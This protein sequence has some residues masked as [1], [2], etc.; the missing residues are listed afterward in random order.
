MT[1]DEPP[2]EHWTTDHSPVN[3]AVKPIFWR[4]IHPLIR[5]V[6]HQYSCK[7]TRA[8]CAALIKS[9]YWTS[10]T[11]L[12]VRQDDYFFKEASFGLQLSRLVYSEAWLQKKK[13]TTLSFWEY[14]RNLINITGILTPKLKSKS[15]N[16]DAHL[17]WRGWG[18]VFYQNTAVNN[19]DPDAYLSLQSS[20]YSLITHR[21]GREKKKKKCCNDSV[22][23]LHHCRYVLTEHPEWSP[24][25]NCSGNGRISKQ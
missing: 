24:H 18:F 1:A 11:S 5:S 25:W 4:L 3:P 8:D 23:P 9:R 7:N 20:M 17:W 2:S 22:N 16:E 14:F 15:Y 13:L 10:P 12:F 19:G 6:S 21:E